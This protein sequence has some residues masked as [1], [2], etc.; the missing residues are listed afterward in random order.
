MDL[1]DIN[2]SSL[3]FQFL[4]VSLLRTAK[5]EISGCESRCLAVVKNGEE[6]KFKRTIRK[7]KKKDSDIY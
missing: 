3:S 6:R 4:C 2:L 7:T 1:F 5:M